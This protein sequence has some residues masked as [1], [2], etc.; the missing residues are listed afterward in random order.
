[1]LSVGARPSRHAVLGKHC[2]DGIPKLFV[3]DGGM[4]AGITIRRRGGDDG[5]PE[6]PG[7]TID[8]MIED[9]EQA[10]E[11]ACAA[12][13]EGQSV[14]WLRS[15]VSD[16]TNDFLTFEARGTNSLLHHSRYALEDRTWLDQRLLGIFGV[17][18][19]RTG[20][21]AVTTQTAEQSLDIDADLLITDACP[22]DVLLQRLGRLHRH[23]SNTRPTAVLIDPGP[24]ERYLAPGGKV[25]GR[26]EQG[27]P[28]VYNNLLSVRATL[29]W[30]QTRKQIN[31]PG[32]CRTLVEQAT[33][34]DFLR[35]MAQSLGG[36]WF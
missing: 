4:L 25:F 27:W 16:A 28:W 32:D 29:D 35:E 26:P 3:D 11:R 30:L 21:V 23:R 2:L 31:I 14:L 17:G 6:A 7:R 36:Q 18:G 1:V 8:V 24:V 22:A 5:L 13:R 12:A 33:H 20:I 9:Y 10:A 15:T 19:Q 34:A